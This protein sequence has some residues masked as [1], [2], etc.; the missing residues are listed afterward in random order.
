M[1]SQQEVE[2]IEPEDVEDDEKLSLQQALDCTANRGHSVLPDDFST[3]RSD[4]TT[5]ISD[6][7][8]PPP[9]SL[10]L[11]GVRQ[12]CR[13]PNEPLAFQHGHLKCHNA[14]DSKPICCPVVLQLC[15]AFPMS[16][17][18]MPTY[19]GTDLDIGIAHFG[20]GG[21]FRA[22]QVQPC[23]KSTAPSAPNVM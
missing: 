2:V 22:H 4:S 10:S 13:S 18:Q 16:D 9:L 5:Q 21:F 19:T 6:V 1:R 15:L 8:P 3:P 17:V 23:Q 12:R 14:T 7:R 20:V 11:F